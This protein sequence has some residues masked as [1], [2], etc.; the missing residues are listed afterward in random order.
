MEVQAYQEMKAGLAT[1]IHL[2]GQARSEEQAQ[3]VIMVGPVAELSQ[4]GRVS[5]V[6]GTWKDAGEC[7]KT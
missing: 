6:A 1:W 5:G 2:T 7:F 3:T 4:G